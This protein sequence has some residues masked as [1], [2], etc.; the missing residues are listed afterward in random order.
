MPD[1]YKRIA[2]DKFKA[3]Y[4][5]ALIQSQKRMYKR[6]AKENLQMQKVLGE[7]VKNNSRNDPANTTEYIDQAMAMHPMGEDEAVREDFI[8]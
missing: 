7:M 8:K 2:S 6:V 5:A 4:G 3:F 1:H